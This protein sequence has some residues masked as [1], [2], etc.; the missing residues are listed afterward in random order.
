M[1]VNKMMPESSWDGTDGL[2]KSFLIQVQVNE[3]Q[4]LQIIFVS[5]C[6]MNWCVCLEAGHV[7]FYLPTPLLPW[8][9][10]SISV[11]SFSHSL[12]PGLSSVAPPTHPRGV[13]IPTDLII[14]FTFTEELGGKGDCSG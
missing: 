12:L 5:L 4:S 8:A 9:I 2:D 1:R 10:P 14:Y 11:T 6:I 3:V 13:L 7:V